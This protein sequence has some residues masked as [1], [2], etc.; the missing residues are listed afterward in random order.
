M[1]VD[2]IKIMFERSINNGVK[3]RNYIG[4]GDSK[5]Y[6]GDLNSKPYGDDFLINKEECVGHVQKR[7]GKRLRDLVKNNVEKDGKNYKKKKSFWQR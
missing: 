7:M 2:A 3:Y 4:D 1:E 5:T 6:T